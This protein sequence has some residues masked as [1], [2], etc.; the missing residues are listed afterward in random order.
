MEMEEETETLETDLKRV[1]RPFWLW[2]HE[3]WGLGFGDS[4]WFSGAFLS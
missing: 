1:S 2:L 3:D 4:S